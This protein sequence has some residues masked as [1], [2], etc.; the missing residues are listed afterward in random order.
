MIKGIA[1]Y[2]TEN[3]N[4]HEALDIGLSFF[5]AIGVCVNAATYYKFLSDGDHNEDHELIDISL[6]RLKE[7][8]LTGAC[9]AFW[10]YRE[11]KEICCFL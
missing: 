4:A 9:D 1:I 2:D 10:L 11:R 3:I 8:V 6:D 5:D 7:N